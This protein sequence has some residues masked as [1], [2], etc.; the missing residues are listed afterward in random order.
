MCC[1]YHCRHGLKD[2]PCVS[3]LQHVLAKVDNLW[4]TEPSSVTYADAVLTHPDHG[5]A[6]IN[7]E[8]AWTWGRV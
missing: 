5:F 4:A 2:A 3:A 6:V 7:A 8:I 1:A